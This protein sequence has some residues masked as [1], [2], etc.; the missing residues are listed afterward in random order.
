MDIII[1][2]TAIAL[3]R[4]LLGHT[5]YIVRG[6]MFPGW[7]VHGMKCPRGETYVVWNVPGWII[8]GWNV[9]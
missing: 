1:L 9:L 5:T 6:D 2:M 4:I 3:Y 7:I 8:S